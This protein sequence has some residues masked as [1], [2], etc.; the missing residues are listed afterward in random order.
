[1]STLDA[2]AQVRRTAASRLAQVHLPRRFAR[3]AAPHGVAAHDRLAHASR[4]PRSRCS[5]PCPRFGAPRGRTEPTTRMPCDL[6]PTG[7]LVTGI[8]EVTGK[9]GGA[10]TEYSWNHAHASA[11][12]AANQPASRAVGSA[13]VPAANASHV[14]VGIGG[15]A[16]SPTRTLVLVTIQME[17]TKGHCLGRRAQH[18]VDRGQAARHRRRA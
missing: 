12:R 1:M 15:Q 11:R 4:S 16:P 2:P 5:P 8:A 10:R 17:W 6:R 3:P 7:G 18:H 9:P 13:P 14:E